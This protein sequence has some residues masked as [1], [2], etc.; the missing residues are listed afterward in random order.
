MPSVFGFLPD[1]LM[2]IADYANVHSVSMSMRRPN[3]LRYS[4]WL[5]ECLDTI[6]SNPE[7]SELDQS[8]VGWVKLLK[9]TED[10][11]TSFRFDDPG[12][13]PDLSEARAQ[14]MVG[15]FE[16][17]LEDWKKEFDVNGMNGRYQFL[18]MLF[19]C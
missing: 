18:G 13:M 11:G 19:F 7:I 17:E 6:T 16:K 8:L 12:N 5:R 4:S 2:Q 15:G 9:I 3:M 10:I 1:L 14:I